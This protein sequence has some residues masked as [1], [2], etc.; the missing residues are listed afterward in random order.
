MELIV[1]IKKKLNNFNFNVSFKCTN[2]ILGILGESGSGKSM[3]LHC[4][5][6]LVKPDEGKIILNGRTLFDSTAKINIP[7]KDRKIGFLFQNYALFPHM[8]VEKNIGYSLSNFSASERNRIINEMLNMMQIEDLRKRYPNEISGGQQQR[9]ALARALAVN[10]E[11]LLLDEPFSAL[12]NHLRS[13][14]LKQMTN[15]LKEYK[16]TTLFVTHNLEEAYELCENLI[17]IAKGRKEG[18]GNKKD[19]FKNPSSLASARVTGC[20]NISKVNF[21]SPETF[22]ALDWNIEFKLSHVPFEKISHIGIRAH[23]IRLAMA[24][25]KNTFDCYPIHTSE[26]PFRRLIYLKINRK[27]T[28][29]SDYDLIWDIPSEQWNLIMHR[30]VPWKICIEEK[31][32]ICINERIETY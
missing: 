5:A 2:S 16:G 19:V 14:M 24:E 10:P 32:I 8:T 4:I 1:D 11:L 15:I 7:I 31:N 9:V 12:D 28:K 17:I 27:N 13:I 29:N 18:E 21:L 25:D 6:G 22:K 23:H 30:P 3:T 20:T 26:T